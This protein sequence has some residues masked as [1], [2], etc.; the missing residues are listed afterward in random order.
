MTLYRPLEIVHI[1][2]ETGLA[3]LLERAHSGDRDVFAVFW[4]AGIPLGHLELTRAQLERPAA[5]ANLI[6]KSIAPAVG[7]RLFA[8]G[9]KGTPRDAPRDKETPEFA[10]LVEVERPLEVLASRAVAAETSA[11]EQRVSVIVCTRNRPDQ[12]ERCLLS[13]LEITDKPQEIIVVDNEP[14]DSATRVVVERFPIITYVAEPRPGLSR[15]RNAGL[16]EAT[17]DII[18][19]TDDDTRVH[20]DWISRLRAGF[21][22]PTVKSVTGLVL[23]AELDT[24]AQ[25]TFEK[26]MG[27]FSQGYQRILYDQNFTEQTK[28]GG[29][30][31]W[32]IGAGANM[33]IRRDVFA[34]LGDFDERLGAGAAGCSE[35]SEFWYRILAHGWHCRYEPAAVVF[36]YHRRDFGSLRRLAR[37]YLRGHVA[38]LFV[39]YARFGDRGNLR[40]AFFGLPRSLFIGAIRE[41]ILPGQRTT[42]L[43]AYVSGYLRGLVYL[44]HAVQGKREVQARSAKLLPVTQRQR[45]RK[46]PLS[47]FLGRNPYPH[48]LS[49][50][51]FYREKM[52]AIHRVAPDGPFERILEV[53]GGQSGLTA[54]LYPGAEVINVELDTEYARSFLNQRGGTYFVGADATRLPFPAASFDAVTFF[55]VLEHITEHAVAASEAKRIVRP[56]GF[57]LVTSPNDRWHFP[58]YRVLRPICP[59]DEQIMSEWGHVRRGYSVNELEELFELTPTASATFINPVTAVGHDFAF[60]KLPEG[61]RRLVC[62]ALSPITWLGY[63]LHRSTGRGTETALCWRRNGGGQPYG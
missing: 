9:F 24:S 61:K 49:E 41:Y 59:T 35:D 8:A 17:G 30:P 14:S 34:A 13:L 60:S 10:P 62:A 56:G 45:G 22:S 39:Q 16:R 40:R 37:D 1:D 15:A 42:I 18:A 7:D 27:G 36:H 55:D 5:L 3:P 20:P 31:V 48:P 53:G 50:G 26:G 63:W 47:E 12:L 33:A 21:D 19:F 57:I 6:A 23:P 58:Y 2:L 52:R 44:P 28:R 25:V 46:A 32:R 11:D 38:A 29:M 54:D 43:P 51:L 4:R